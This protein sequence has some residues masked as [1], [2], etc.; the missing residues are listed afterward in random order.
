[1]AITAD[2]PLRFLGEPTSIRW[3]LDNSAAY[4]IYKG[5]AGVI[6]QTGDASYPI[7]GSTITVAADDVCIGIAAAQQAVL[8]TDREV[9]NVVE[10]YT[11]PSIV[12]FKST[13][14]AIA[15]LEDPVYQ[16]AEGALST[17]AADVPEIGTVFW[18]EDGYVYVKLNTPQICS[19]A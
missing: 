5:S 10:F 7:A 2:Q 9:D 13:V 17:T 3:V 1:M 16:D 6:D 18:V 15:D 12:G 14:F 19:G 4:T 11:Y 8:T